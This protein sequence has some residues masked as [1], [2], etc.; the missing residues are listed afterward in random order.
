MP[1][2]LQEEVLS[3]RQQQQAARAV[4][5]NQ[6]ANANE[7]AADAIAFL[8]SLN[9]SLR[10]QVLADV[11]D[12]VIQVRSNIEIN[13]KLETFRFC[14]KIWPPKQTESVETTNMTS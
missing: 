12:T 10:A 14:P 6:N 13:L 1:P 3:Q 4:A 7:P 5:V 2:E 9:P 11:D 8:D